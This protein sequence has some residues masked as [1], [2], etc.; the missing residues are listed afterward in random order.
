MLLLFLPNWCITSNCAEAVRPF[1]PVVILKNA[2][3]ICS[4]YDATLPFLVTLESQWSISVTQRDSERSNCQGVSDTDSTQRQEPHKALKPEARA[5]FTAERGLKEPNME[6]H[7]H[8]L[9][10]LC[11]L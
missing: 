7:F 2:I 10:Q 5:T 3:N 11:D 8:L 6:R 1:V 4:L 9:T